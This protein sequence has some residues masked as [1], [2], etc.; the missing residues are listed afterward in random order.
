MS[1]KL[2]HDPETFPG[3]GL[4][5]IEVKS[6]ARL[7]TLFKNDEVGGLPTFSPTGLK[8]NLLQSRNRHCHSGEAFGFRERYT[9]L[10]MPRRYPVL[11]ALRCFLVNEDSGQRDAIFFFRPSTF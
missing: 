7:G 10:A 6:N 2:L 1:P 4:L 5:H 9:G 11:H 8:E 3:R